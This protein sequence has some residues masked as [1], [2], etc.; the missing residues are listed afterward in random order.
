MGFGWPWEINW[1]FSF[2]EVS[3]EHY[4]MDIAIT[5]NDFVPLGWGNDSETVNFNT[6]KSKLSFKAIKA[7]VLWAQLSSK[8]FP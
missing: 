4:V 7:N 6:E 1:P 3:V 2:T 5:I 8:P